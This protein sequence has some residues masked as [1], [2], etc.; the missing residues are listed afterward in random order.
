MPILTVSIYKMITERDNIN[1]K[2]NKVFR[3]AYVELNLTHSKGQSQ[4][5]THFNCKRL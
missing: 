4:G 5:R 1:M 3:L 2:P